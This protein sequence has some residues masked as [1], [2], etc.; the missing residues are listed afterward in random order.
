LIDVTIE[1][2]G[3]GFDTSK[4]RPG[5]GISNMIYRVE[6]FNGALVINSTPGNGCK[7]RIRIP[8]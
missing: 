5:I 8:C 4:N 1:D 3:K 2:D 6:S 7:L